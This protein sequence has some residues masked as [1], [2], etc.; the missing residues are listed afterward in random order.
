MSEELLIPRVAMN[1]ARYA[2]EQAFAAPTVPPPAPERP[3]VVFRKRRASLPSATESQTWND[4]SELNRARAPRVFRAVAPVLAEPKP[5]SLSGGQAETDPQSSSTPRRRRQKHR[6]SSVVHLVFSSATAA[7]DESADLGAH[8]GADRSL[9][10]QS[11]SLS[12]LSDELRASSRRWQTVTESMARLG[13]ILDDVERLQSLRFEDTE[14]EPHWANLQ[15][16]A[17][18]LRRQLE[19]RRSAGTAARIF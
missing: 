1:A 13:S 19:A 18:N 2:A 9:D 14:L 5:E 11:S 8:A 16:R 12:A 7:S 3:R 17:E 10:A 15:I 4:Q 6:P